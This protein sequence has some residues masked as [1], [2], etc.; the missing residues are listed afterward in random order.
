MTIDTRS[1]T[2]RKLLVAAATGIL[3][4]APISLH[5][6]L[7]R[8]VRAD[9]PTDRK[10]RVM[11]QEILSRETQATATSGPQPRVLT[12]KP[13][14]PAAEEPQLPVVRPTAGEQPAQRTQAP[15]RRSGAV[16]YHNRYKSAVQQELQRLNQNSDRKGATQFYVPP[17]LY[18]AAQR[19]SEYQG[20]AVQPQRTKFTDWLKPRTWR[21]RF[22]RSRNPGPV[23]NPQADD[24]NI[25]QPAP[26]PQPVQQPAPRAPQPNPQPA[27]P[28]VA[29]RVSAADSASVP[30]PIPLEAATS[31]P[32]SL[33]PVPAQSAPQPSEPPQVPRVS[34]EIFTLGPPE[35]EPDVAEPQVGEP[36][37]QQPVEKPQLITIERTPAERTPASEQKDA[38]SDVETPAPRPF[39]GAADAARP[40]R[41]ANEAPQ[42]QI[43]F[44]FGPA[45][46]RE[47]S[48]FDEPQAAP[49]AELP[50]DPE[51]SSVAT[52][53]RPTLELPSEDEEKLPVLTLETSDEQP[54][55]EADAAPNV[56]KGPTTQPELSLES[57]PAAGPTLTIESESEIAADP[58]PEENPFA[59]PQDESS[60]EDASPPQTPFSGLK[61]EDD[62]HAEPLPLPPTSEP[63]SSRPPAS[64]ENHTPL[65]AQIPVPP[66]AG[67][68]LT[69]PRTTVRRTPPRTTPPPIA[70]TSNTTVA[71]A[72]LPQVANQRPLAETSRRTSSTVREKMARIASRGRL[73]GFKGFCPVMLRDHRELVD[74]KFDQSAV[75]NGKQYWF[76]SEEAKHTFLAD[77]TA[78]VPAGGGIDL[79]HF[80]QTGHEQ[81]G[82]LEHAV[83][84]RGQLYLF[85][86]AASKA[87]FMAA[88]RDH[89]PAE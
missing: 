56:D 46:E 48:G 18:E 89:I 25:G 31:Q 14:V 62:P 78:Y 65:A 22:S 57:K 37:V 36:A 74:T 83:W 69:A 61:L 70:S 38:L 7:S 52:E 1:R 63:V 51:E 3:F 80:K 81:E 55:S 82:S 64:V 32:I 27:T 45:P 11:L 84:F 6:G 33:Q 58:T 49:P 12:I 43:E 9:E 85:S 24:T 39:P 4:S 88:P 20:G 21:R 75:Y 8:A 47:S 17:E 15:P 5:S 30:Q 50:F 29:P 10:P 2:A 26:L 87:D 71:P 66:S 40:E 67:P 76:S 23:Y 72:Q 77:P 34:Q 73:K 19:A 16:Q 68:T 42:P 44:I 35:E 28:F 60:S 54:L 13:Q 59:A 41:A 79:V 86:S 53:A